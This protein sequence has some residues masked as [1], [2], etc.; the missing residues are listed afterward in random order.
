MYVTFLTAKKQTTKNTERYLLSCVLLKFKILETSQLSFK[1]QNKT[2]SNKRIYFGHYSGFSL[3]NEISNYLK[4]TYLNWIRI[5]TKFIT[6]SVS[7]HFLNSQP[8]IQCGDSKVMCIVGQNKIMPVK[9]Q[10][11]MSLRSL[12]LQNIDIDIDILG[13]KS[14]SWK[15][16]ID[17]LVQDYSN[18][19]ANVP[20]LMLSC[21]KPS[22]FGVSCWQ[23]SPITLESHGMLGWSW[24]M[25]CYAYC[26]TTYQPYRWLIER[27]QCLHC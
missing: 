23:S 21:T 22:I 4:K 20:E 7:K 26:W 3:M 11:D 19:I 8:I 5:Y 27:L 10:L 18:S 9:S 16:Y 1:K 24:W 13:R 6:K 15:H 17:S 25:T 14:I 12:S 2:K